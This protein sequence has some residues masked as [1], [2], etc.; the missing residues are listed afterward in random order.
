MATLGPTPIT[1][2]AA[3][4]YSEVSSLVVTD[5]VEMVR[6][7]NAGALHFLHVNHDTETGDTAEEGRRTEL[8]EWL[9]AR[10]QAPDGLP[11]TVKIVAHEVSG[12]PSEVIVQMATDLVC[13]VVLVG[14]HGRTGMQRLL[15]GSVAETAVRK[16]GCSV[17]VVRPK[18]HYQAIPEIAPPCPACVEA[19]IN[20]RGDALWCEQHTEKHGRRHTYYNTGLAAWASQRL[21]L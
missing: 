6:Q 16:C 19:R 20:S 2:L 4:D 12:N 5:A 8:L 7:K 14:T 11:E 15:M 21:I 17:V 18:L 13:D 9:W 1:I 3:V 10:L